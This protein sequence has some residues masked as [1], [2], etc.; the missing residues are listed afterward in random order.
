MSSSKSVRR[1]L[2]DNDAVYTTATFI[3]QSF[4]GISDL[5]GVLS[6]DLVTD[7]LVNAGYSVTAKDPVLTDMSPTASYPTSKQSFSSTALIAAISLGTLAFIALVTSIAYY[8]RI[9]KKVWNDRISLLV[10]KYFKILFSM[11]ITLRN[12][13]YLQ[14]LGPAWRSQVI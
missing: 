4:L 6:G 12:F 14:F 5:R 9:N 11:R 10:S 3:I 1:N 2:L 13:R 7:E 8:F